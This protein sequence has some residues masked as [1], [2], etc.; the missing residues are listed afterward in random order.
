[1]CRESGGLKET[2]VLQ[3]RSDSMNAASALKQRQMNGTEI[4]QSQDP[5]YGDKR[6]F[7]S[8]I[9]SDGLLNKSVETDLKPFR[10]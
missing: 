6:H 10:N 9:A 5:L 4:K 8:T 3:G 2:T 1:M 7:Q